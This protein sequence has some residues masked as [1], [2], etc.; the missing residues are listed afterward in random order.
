MSLCSYGC[1]NEGQYYNPGTKKHRCRKH[2]SQCPEVRKRSRI[3]GRKKALRRK[4]VQNLK[5]YEKNY[6]YSFMID[7]MREDPKTKKVQVR[8]TYS[9]CEHSEKNDGWFDL[10]PTL[11][12]FREYDL[13]RDWDGYN[14]YC[15]DECRC[16]CP[17]R[18]KNAQTLIKERA[19]IIGGVNDEEHEWIGMKIDDSDKKVW[20]KV[21]LER[22]GYLCQWCEIAPA[23]HVH[24]IN[25]VKTH[26]MEALDPPNGLS[27]CM[28]CHY[29]YGHPAGDK[30]CSTGNLAQ[31]VC[32]VIINEKYVN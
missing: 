17:I 13:V 12:C 8:C 21:C 11:A 19:L 6:P 30:D 15:S 32:S 9:E 31:K 26:P 16:L 20:R 3:E 29:K 23:E 22:D 2:F 18:G 14:Y 25:P 27:C 10:T 4:Q 5:F 1:G 7:E 28:T 24:H